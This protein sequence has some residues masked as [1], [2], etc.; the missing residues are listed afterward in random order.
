MSRKGT[1]T[2][3]GKVLRKSDTASTEKENVFFCNNKL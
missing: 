2:A 1:R 3:S